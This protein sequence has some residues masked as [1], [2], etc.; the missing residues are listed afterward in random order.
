M[1]TLRPITLAVAPEKEREVRAMLKDYPH[2]AISAADHL[3][4]DGGSW[5]WDDGWGEI[6]FFSSLKQ[7]FVENF[8]YY[9]TEDAPNG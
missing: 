5:N 9:L 2:V 1:K 4:P 8:R 3:S 7:P 6:F